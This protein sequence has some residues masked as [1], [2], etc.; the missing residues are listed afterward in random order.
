MYKA[1]TQILAVILIVLVALVIYDV[2]NRG[3]VKEQA[4]TLAAQIKE[5]DR[6]ISILTQKVGVL[7][8]DLSNASN[9]IDELQQEYTVRINALKDRVAL[10]RKTS[11]QPGAVDQEVQNYQ[12]YASGLSSLIESPEMVQNVR[13]RI[14]ENQVKVI[15]GSFIKN[16]LTTAEDT[17][18]ITDMLVNRYFLDWKMRVELM[19]FDLTRR[20]RETII[21]EVESDQEKIDLK[22]KARVGDELFAKYLELQKT[23]EAREFVHAFNSQLAMENLP[24]LSG[25]Q[26]RRL[27]NIMTK[28]TDAFHNNPAYIEYKRLPPTQLTEKQAQ[29]IVRL[30][31][32]TF[33]NIRKQ[34]EELLQP[35]QKE[36]LNSFLDHLLNQQ[37]T[38]MEFTLKLINKE[39]S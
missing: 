38:S 21:T 14:E 31:T 2:K 10:A 11:G 30:L 13:S 4:D 26:S 9:R 20:E 27:I 5:R 33:T 6:Q 23:G 7:E 24:K 17:Q 32:D 29:N 15:Y 37:L 8:R 25:I 19:N 18:L 34:S 1:L 16:S 39:R 28:E 35:K 3:N 36:V 22:I 12:K